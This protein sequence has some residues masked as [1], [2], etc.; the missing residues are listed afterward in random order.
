MKFKSIAFQ[1]DIA[2]Q[3]ENRSTLKEII[4]FGGQAGYN[5]LFLYGE[6]AL[7]YKSHPCCSYPWA[8]TQK[9]FIDLRDYARNII[10]CP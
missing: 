9:E 8:L 10:V 4:D 3:M 6:G 7:E 5:E 2:R 1:I